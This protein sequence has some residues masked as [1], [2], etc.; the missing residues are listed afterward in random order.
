MDEWISGE[1]RQ[2]GWYDVLIDDKEEDRLQWFVCVMNPRK[3]YWKDRNGTPIKDCD[4]K[5][6]G[7][8]S[9]SYW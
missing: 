8:A 3:K 6:T 7:R 1:P 9:A 4:I 2:A 5:W